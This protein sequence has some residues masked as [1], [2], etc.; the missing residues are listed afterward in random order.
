MNYIPVIKMMGGMG[1]HEKRSTLFISINF[2]F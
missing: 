1:A 2:N